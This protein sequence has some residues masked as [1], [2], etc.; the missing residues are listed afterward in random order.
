LAALVAQ[1]GKSFGSQMP[2][3][4]TGSTLTQ[5]QLDTIATWITQGAPN[6]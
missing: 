4:A 2:A 5:A 6:N 1:T 3:P